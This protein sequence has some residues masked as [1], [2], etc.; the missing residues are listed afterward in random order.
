MMPIGAYYT[1]LFLDHIPKFNTYYWVKDGVAFPLEND[2]HYDL[3]HHPA[4]SHS[5]P[6]LGGT[7][8]HWPEHEPLKLMQELGEG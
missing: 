4:P 5:R 1:S 8:Y 2:S 7:L 6:W 3:E